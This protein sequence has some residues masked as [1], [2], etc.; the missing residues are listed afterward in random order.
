MRGQHLTGP[1]CPVVCIGNFTAGGTGKTPLA[2]QVAGELQRLGRKAVFLTRGY[3]GRRAGPHWVDPAA[4]KAADVGDEPLLLARQAPTLV[5]RDRAAGAKAIEA[6]DRAAD[7][8]IMDD[9][10]AESFAGQGS[11]A[12]RGRRTPRPRQRTRYPRRPFACSARF[13]VRVGRMPSSSTSRP[14]PKL[15][16]RQSRDWLRQRFPGPVL[17]ASVQPTEDVA[18]LENANVVAFA[19]IGRAAAVL[20]SVAAGAAPTSSTLCRFP[21]ITRLRTTTRNA[22]WIWHR[23]PRQRW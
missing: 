1:A 15:A 19:G 22:S 5:A 20:R 7:V 13:S 10:L 8:I 11:V 21:I 14:M 23:L 2:L 12:R 16:P 4:D 18:W 17:S 3:G 9:G 6:G